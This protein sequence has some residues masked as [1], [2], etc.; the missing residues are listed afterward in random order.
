MVQN[1]FHILQYISTKYVIF[2]ITPILVCL[3]MCG[4][5]KGNNASPHYIIMVYI[6]IVSSASII[7]IHWFLLVNPLL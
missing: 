2:F 5:D 3:Y 7:A 6:Y 1:L 4:P